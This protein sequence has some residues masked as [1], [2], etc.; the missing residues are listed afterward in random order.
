MRTHCA[1]LLLLLLAPLTSVGRGPLPHCSMPLVLEGVLKVQLQLIDLE[2][3]QLTHQA[4]Q[5][6][7]GRHTVAADIQHDTT[8]WNVRPVHDL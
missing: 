2:V 7:E 4:A 6:L 5:C 8:V 3:G 1:Q